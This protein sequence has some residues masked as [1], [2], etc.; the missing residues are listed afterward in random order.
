[1]QQLKGVHIQECRGFTREQAFKD[2]LFEVTP[3]LY[4]SN[5]TSAW[6]K[7]GKPNPGTVTFK[8]FMVNELEKRTKF[9]PGFGIY[10]TVD[11]GNPDSREFPYSIVKNPIKET[12]NWIKIYQIRE[13][14]LKREQDEI[15][16]TK[17]G[18]VVAEYLNLEEATDAVKALICQ[19]KRNYSIVPVKVPD[20]VPISAYCF[21]TPSSDAREGIYY[22]AGVNTL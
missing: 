18:P 1:M 21:Y 20:V 11:P 19:N 10:I 16:I 7:A 5:V 14:E 13:D 12:R 9:K 15:T 22:A 17:I 8:R 4:H 2:L 6:K 3:D